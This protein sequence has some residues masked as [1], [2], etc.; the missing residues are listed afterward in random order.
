MPD[1][2]PKGAK[3]LCELFTTALLHI[4]PSFLV[5]YDPV[6]AVNCVESPSF[7]SPSRSR[8]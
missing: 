4:Q 3:G 6:H 1:T 7:P 5:K 8:L 2:I